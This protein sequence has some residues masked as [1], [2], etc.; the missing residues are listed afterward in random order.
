MTNG[1][2]EHECRGYNYFGSEAGQSISF[3]RYYLQ[4]DSSKALTAFVL[5]N[6]L[7]VRLWLL[8]Q[9]LAKR[10]ASEITKKTVVDKW[11][12]AVYTILQTANC[13]CIYLYIITI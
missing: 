1:F 11:R 13:S 5:I 8:T 9:R 6:S 4:P 7:P 12:L 3:N 10:H 2:C